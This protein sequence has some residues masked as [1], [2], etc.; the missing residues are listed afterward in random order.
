MFDE[1]Y[2]AKKIAYYSDIK[3]RWAH[4]R[5]SYNK[6]HFKDIE[7]AEGFDNFKHV[8]YPYTMFLFEFEDYLTP[9]EESAWQVIRGIG[10]I[11]L[12]PQVPALQYFIDF[13]NPKFKVGIELDGKQHDLEA[14]KIRDKKIYDK[15]GYRIIRITGKQSFDYSLM[16]SREY[17]NDKDYEIAYREWALNTIEGIIYSVKSVYFEYWEISEFHEFHKESVRLNC[18]LDIDDNKLFYTISDEIYH[19]N[20]DKGEKD[21]LNA[22]QNYKTWAE[23][24][25]DTVKD[26]IKTARQNPFA[27]EIKKIFDYDLSKKY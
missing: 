8:I 19:K 23:D 13:A 17:M 6:Q 22:A 11:P 1:V 18:L 26:V 24:M 9:I 15:L 27:D 2:Y 25:D 10:G 20:K 3:N 7:S 16:P 14:D 21:V 5:D 12:Y 4:I